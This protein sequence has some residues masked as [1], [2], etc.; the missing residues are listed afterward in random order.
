MNEKLK[1]SWGHIIAFL[2]IIFVSYITFVGITYKTNGDFVMASIGM[3]VIDVLLL[4]FFI[5]A[6]MM[7]GTGRKFSRYIIFERIFIFG[8]PIIFILTMIPFSHFWNVRSN[9]KVIVKQFTDAISLSKQLFTDYEKYSDERTT[10]YEKMLS[11]VISNRFIRNSEFIN[12]GFIDGKEGTQKKNMLKTLQLQLRSENYDSLKNVALNWIESS[13]NGAS[14][15]N[16]FLLGNTKEIKSA[17][18]DWQRQLVEFSVKKASNEEFRGYNEVKTFDEVSNSI[19]N[20]QKGLDNLKN[21]YTNLTGPNIT[22]IIIGILI[23]LMLL[24]P[25]FIQDR[26]TKN[27]Y[28]LLGTE[29]AWLKGKIKKSSLGNDIITEDHSD[30]RN[31][32]LQRVVS[33]DKDEDYSSFTL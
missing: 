26:H 12:C 31:I 1:F 21:Q 4:L 24:L 32:P 13:S 15:W 30:S 17:I 10:N 2:A 6:Q 20:A 9:D 28:R 16:V 3:I 27:I 29:R 11:R 22:A 19:L 5:G 14:T 8:S 7:K 25:Y 18:G 23:Y 33:N